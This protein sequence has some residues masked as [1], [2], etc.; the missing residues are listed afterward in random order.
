MAA[1][2]RVQ[3]SAPRF[4]RLDFLCLALWATGSDAILDGTS[5]V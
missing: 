3:L 1:P 2:E 5:L 4:D